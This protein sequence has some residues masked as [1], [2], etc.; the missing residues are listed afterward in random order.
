MTP[1]VFLRHYTAVADASPVPVLL[2]NY[3]AI[4]GVNL[5]PETVGRLAEHPNIAGIKETGTDISQVAAYVDAAPAPFSVIAGSVPVFY[6]SLCVGAIGGVLALACVAP[7]VCIRLF[8][9]TTAGRHD[10]ARALQ[11]EVTPLARLVTTGHGVPGLKA[12]MDL[13]GY[14]GGDPRPPLGPAPTSA[15]EQIGTE[16]NRLRKACEQ[17]A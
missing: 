9:H 7:E 16:L 14:I 5:A 6:P 8:E 12:A 3:P 1:E 10:A 2:Y 13:A 4:T 15:I 11:R 17:Y